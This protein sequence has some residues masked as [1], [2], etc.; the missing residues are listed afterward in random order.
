MPG[1]RRCAGSARS[2]STPGAVIPAYVEREFSFM[3]DG[4]RIRGRWDRVDIEPAGDGIA[5]GKRSARPP[6]SPHADVVDARRCRSSA[7]SG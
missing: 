6:T 3:L 4:D 1:A 2:S 5:A 7:A